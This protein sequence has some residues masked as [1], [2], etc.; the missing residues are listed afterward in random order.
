[1]QDSSHVEE[2]ERKTGVR[3][4]GVQMVMKAVTMMENQQRKN[5]SQRLRHQ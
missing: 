1:M 2:G 4:L 5:C 3:R